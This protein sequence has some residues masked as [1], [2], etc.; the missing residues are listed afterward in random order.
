MSHLPLV[1]VICTS[2]NHEKYVFKALNSVLNQNYDA[3]ELIIVDNGSQDNTVKVIEDWLWL[4]DFFKPVKTFFYTQRNNYCRIFNK[5]L[6]LCTGTYVIDLAADDELLPSHIATAVS[7]LESSNAAVYFSNVYLWFEDGSLKPFYPVTE[8]GDLIQKVPAGDVYKYVVERYAIS[9]VSLVFKRQVL[10]REGGYDPSLVY[11]DFD[12]LVRL[13]RKYRFVFHPNIGVKKRILSSSFS[14]Q[15]YRVGS[16]RMLPSTYHVL[17]KIKK[18]NVTVDENAALAK[19]ILFESKHALASANFDT[20]EKM[21]ALAWSLKVKRLHV[22]FFRIWA[23]SR[24]N[25]SSIYRFLKRD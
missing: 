24:I 6:D 19:R 3:I 17:L 22:F 10:K 15:Q 9:T 16:C 8:A 5:A 14:A 12:I 4:H 23:Q 2:Y 20:A 18:M 25:V 1:S 11:E 7:N 13:A 21:L